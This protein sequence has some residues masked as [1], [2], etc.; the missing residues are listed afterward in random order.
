[1]NEY[2]TRDQSADIAESLRRFFAEQFDQELNDLQASLLLD[3]IMKE[4]AP[5]AYNSGVEDAR[6]YLASRVDDLPGVC[7]AQGLTYW[8]TTP[9][10]ARGVRRKPGR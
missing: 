9:G 6:A 2:V 10:A 1:M 5:F 7:F 8:E 3:Y 4:I